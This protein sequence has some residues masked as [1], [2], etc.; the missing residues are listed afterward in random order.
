VSE[1]AAVELDIF[2]GVPNPTWNLSEADTTL[3]LQK[4]SA[5][6]GAAPKQLANPL[7]Y[8]GFIVTLR[9]GTEDI[10]ARIQQGTVELTRGG[11]TTYR[12]DRGRELERWLLNSGRP[13][14]K[15]DLL[16]I[17]ENDLAK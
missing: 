2:S 9:Q 3:F 5:L 13:V 17:V 4:I 11:A 16:A 7:G 15:S 12:A 6:P 14:L 8:R 10:Q 1:T